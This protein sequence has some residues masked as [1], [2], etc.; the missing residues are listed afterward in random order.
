M[1]DF[2]HISPRCL[3]CVC[4]CTQQT[5]HMRDCWLMMTSGVCVCPCQLSFP[6]LTCTL[7]CSPCSMILM[8][9]MSSFITLI[10]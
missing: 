8:S 5:G 2:S 1:I 3:V 4:L 7:S 10:R 6:A 9:S